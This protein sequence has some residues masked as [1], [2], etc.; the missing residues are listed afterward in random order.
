MSYFSAIVPE[1][2][3]SGLRLDKFVSNLPNGMNRSKLKAGLVDVFVNGKKQKISYKVK[4]FDKIEIK[5]ED[6]VPD[7][8]VAEDIPLDIIYEDENVT[9]VNKKQGMV[10]HP[11]AGNWTGTLV[12]ALLFHWGRQDIK[13]LKDASLTDILSARRPGIVHRLDKDTSG[14]IITA[15]NRASEEWLQNQIKIH[16]SR[17]EYILIVVGRPRIRSGVIKTQIIRDPRDRKKYKAVV[18]SDEGK[19]AITYFKCICCYGN[20]S[21]IRVRLGTGRTHQ[22]RVHMKY[23]NCPILG[24]PIYAHS[25]KIFPDAT[26]ML[27]ARQLS[28]RLPASKDFST[29][30]AAVP[31]R[32]KKVLA[33][34]HRSEA[35]TEMPFVTEADMKAPLLTKGVYPLVMNHKNKSK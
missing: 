24:D 9:V 15:K 31:E 19:T 18:D 25:D 13:Q 17:K 21:L 20:Y 5:W 2:V 12:N 11:A 7:D 23:M 34:L 26:L 3:Q 6:N 32:F 10:T 30:K 1:S 33:H 14:V 16:N 28:I 27:H 8:I 4:P 29:F 22:I 35:R